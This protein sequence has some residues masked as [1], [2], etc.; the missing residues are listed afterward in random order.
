MILRPP[1][2]EDVPAIVA[3]RSRFAP[4]RFSEERLTREWSEPGFDPERDARVADGGYAAVEDYGDGPAWIELHGEGPEP[5]LEWALN[6]ATADRVFC[7]GWKGDEPV[8]RALESA[9]FRAVRRSYRM[10]IDLGDAPESVPPPAGLELRAFLSGEE[11]AVYETHMETFEDSWEHVHMPYD[12]WLHWNVERPGFDPAL[13]LVAVEGEAIAGIVLCR[14]H[15]EDPATGWVTILGVRREWRRRGLGEALLR[16][17]F[18][19]LARRGC[20]R[21]VLG[22]DAESLTGAH[23]LYERTGMHVAARFD[24]YEKTS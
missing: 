14:I 15:D 19:E 22:V 23:R 17:G 10:A 12:R 11:R 6:R 18:A 9:G 20:G 24:V 5:L 1:R 3:M 13:W 8:R 16:A 21:A 4:E 7:G 2:E